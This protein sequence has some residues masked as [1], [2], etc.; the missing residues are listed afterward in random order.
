MAFYFVAGITRGFK[1]AV[2]NLDVL[3]IFLVNN[4]HYFRTGE[5]GFGEF[6]F[7]FL[8]CLFRL[9]IFSYIRIYTTVPGPVIIFVKY[10]DTAR[11]EVDRTTVLAYVFIDEILDRLSLGKHLERCFL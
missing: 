1:K 4:D 2:I 5:E 10:G 3:S 6:F 8:Q 7:R 9:N 11:H